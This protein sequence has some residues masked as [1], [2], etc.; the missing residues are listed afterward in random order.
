MS[1]ESAEAPRTPPKYVHGVLLLHVAYESAPAHVGTARNDVVR[2]LRCHGITERLDDAR[3]L[4]S[5]LVTNAVRHSPGAGVSVTARLAPGTLFLAVC[6]GSTAVPLRH[7]PTARDEHGRGLV[8]LDLLADDWGVA[9]A[10]RKTKV[11][12]CCLNLAAPAHRSP[13]AD[14]VTS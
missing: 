6:D 9:V 8:L 3:L 1:E 7:R 2:A 14:E 10:G 5:E 12:W 4:V 11:V 13:T